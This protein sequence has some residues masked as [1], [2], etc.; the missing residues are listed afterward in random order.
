MSKYF[1]QIQKVVANG[2]TDDDAQRT[3]QQEWTADGERAS[4]LGT[5]LHA[6][7]EFKENNEYIE[8]DP[9]ITAEVAQFEAFKASEWV[10]S[11][12]LECVRT[13]LCV[14]YRVEG[15]NVC[16][17]QIDALYTD[18]DGRFYIV[19]FKRVS[20]KHALTVDDEGFRGKTGI[21]PAALLP[22]TNFIHY[23]LQTSA[24]NVML[25]QTHKIDCGTRMF[26]L[27]MHADRENYQLVQCVDLRS[28]AM[29]MLGNERL[30]LICL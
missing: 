18:N 21:G 5:K 1:D 19:D 24:Y 3:I 22:D 15:I 7:C 26:L 6:Y 20:K 28:Q 10:R 4:R 27:R 13:E 14:S 29:D 12:G 16:A 30:R 17:G 8:L 25:R 23:S 9:E 2:G 11:K